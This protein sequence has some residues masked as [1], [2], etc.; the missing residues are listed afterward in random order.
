VP[1]SSAIRHD[2]VKRFIDVAA[3]VE[4]RNLDAVAAD[5]TQRIGQLQFPLEYHASVIGDYALSHA[6]RA[7]LLT[8]C[9]AALIG[10]FFLL[11][12]AFSSWRLAALAFFSLPAALAGGALMARATGGVLSIGPLAG[13]LAVFG[14]AIYNRLILFSRYQQL[15]RNE[16]ERLGPGLALRGALERLSPM[17]LASFAAAATVLPSL[18]LG[19]VPGLEMIRPMTLVLLGGLISATVHDL[20]FLPAMFLS[21]AVSSIRETDPL[22]ETETSQ[23]FGPVAAASGA[24]GD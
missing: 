21:L 13:L 10:I 4:G 18:I 9:I 14:I 16:G 3:D 12:S 11:Q 7:R 24:A 22:L 8:L 23:A 20:L 19:D 2:A 17:L 15:E 1:A 5:I 6:T